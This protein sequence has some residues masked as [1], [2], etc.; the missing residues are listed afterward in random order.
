[1]I[2]AMIAIAVVLLVS[3]RYD[4][5]P[6]Q[7]MTPPGLEYES[8][9]TG[10]EDFRDAIARLSTSGGPN[11]PLRMSRQ[12]G[13]FSQIDMSA[14]NNDPVLI[15]PEIIELSW[16]EDLSAVMTVTAADTYWADGREE[17]EPASTGTREPGTVISESHFDANE[18]GVPSSSLPGDSPSDL[19]DLMVAMGLPTAEAGAGNLIETIDSL[20]GLWTLTNHQQAILLQ[21]LVDAGDYDVLGTATDRAGRQVVGIRA[22][23][24]IFPGIARVILVSTE[25]GRIVGSET[26]RTIDEAPLAA[27]DVIAYKLW[28]I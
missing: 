12:L 4:T 26:E 27:G 21:M 3:V 10:E 16:N 17:G 7:A 18:F 13:W 24:S 14:S 25:T 5:D 15:A 20:M 8:I 23:P 2:G 22:E 28:E 11:K 9:Q 1:M 19:H 6:A